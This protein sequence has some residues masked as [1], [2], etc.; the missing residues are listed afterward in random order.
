MMISN[1]PP[2]AQA[3]WAQR[4]KSAVVPYNQDGTQTSYAGQ[5][6]EMSPAMTSGIVGAMTSAAPVSSV[7]GINAAVQ[8]M[9]NAA[10]SGGSNKDVGNATFGSIMQSALQFGLSSLFEGIPGV[11]NVGTAVGMEA[12]SDDPN[13]GRAALSSGLPMATSVVS[14]AVLPGLGM[15]A[16]PL[17][18]Y[19]AQRSLK[20]GWLGDATNS[21]SKERMRDAVED[22]WGLCVDDTA[23]MAASQRSIDGINAGASEES[24]FEDKLGLGLEANYGT[25]TA[26]QL[27]S[28]VE[29]ELGFSSLK[30]YLD[31]MSHKLKDFGYSSDGS[32]SKR[33]IDSI[34]N[35]E[36]PGQSTISNPG[37]PSTSTIS[38]PDSHRSRSRELASR[39]DEE[40]LEQ[41]E[42]EA[43][44]AE[45]DSDSNDRDSSSSG[46]GIGGVS[47][48][49]LGKGVRIGETTNSGSYSS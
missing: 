7:P 43:R 45:N 40:A 10:A 22:E 3:E 36:S 21:R 17:A 20:D 49:D 1:L 46:S 6:V 13:Y 2:D 18:S 19:Y 48:A 25:T 12:M 4:S 35:P 44:E 39:F 47:G 30:S 29:K 16:G 14:N 34:S 15:I 5:E 41:M 9:T 32:S 8:G 27:R 28:M 23:S 38:N 11:A 42:K 33:E 26:G 37:S 24:K 31:S